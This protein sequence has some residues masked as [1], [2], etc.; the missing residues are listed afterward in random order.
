MNEKDI[1]MKLGVCF[2]CLRIARHLSRDYNAEDIERFMLESKEILSL[3]KFNLR[4]WVH[5]GV[6][7]AEKRYSI[8]RREESSCFGFNLEA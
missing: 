2:K 3:A 4:G 6:S 8:G 7:E 1:L 5:T